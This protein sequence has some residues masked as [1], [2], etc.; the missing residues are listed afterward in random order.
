M[1]AKRLGWTLLMSVF[2]LTGCDDR[3]YED[4]PLISIWS[5]QTR[6][7]GKWEWALA[8]ETRLPS[9]EVRNLTGQLAGKI[10]EFNSDNTVSIS[11]SVSGQWYLVSK[12]EELNLIFESSATAYN[13]RQL[14]RKDMWLEFVTDSIQVEW[15]LVEE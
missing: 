4:G 8:R 14:T 12:N 10:I 6:V 3:K 11:D 1:I 5:A 2:L 13:I 9:G 15:Q 7:E